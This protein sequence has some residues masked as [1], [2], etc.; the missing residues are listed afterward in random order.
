MIYGYG[1]RTLN[2]LR[3]ELG[4]E[5]FYQS[6]KAYFKEMKFGVSTTADFMRVMQ[7]TSGKDLSAFFESHRVFVSDQK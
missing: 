4:D 6:M 5:Q 1:S 2:I 3:L 7:K